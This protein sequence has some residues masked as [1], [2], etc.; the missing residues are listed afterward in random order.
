MQLVSGISSNAIV[1]RLAVAATIAALALT[2]FAAG[3]ALTTG[4]P[5]ER[6]F[7]SGERGSV[8]VLAAHT[9]SSSGSSKSGGGSTNRRPR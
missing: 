3:S 5:S 8:T 2:M 4:S 9:Q 6:G 7:A 1:R